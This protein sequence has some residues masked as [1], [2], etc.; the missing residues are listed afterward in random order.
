M[1]MK[2]RTICFILALLVIQNELFAQ[3]YLTEEYEKIYLQRQP[4]DKIIEL[5]GIKS[6]MTIGEVGA[7][8]GRM[9]V[10]LAREVGPSGKIYANDI[11]DL[12]LAYLKGR[13]RR[14]G[15]SNVDII[16]GMTDDPLL[17]EK[18]LDMA[19]MALVYHMLEK[20]DKLLENIKK[21]LKP[22]AVL[23]ILDPSDADID[24]EFGIDRSK[25]DVKTPTIR[26]RIANSASSAGYQV[27]KVDTTLPSDIIFTLRPYLEK[28]KIPAGEML[29]SIT[30]K[31]NIKAARKEFEKIKIDTLTYDL[32]EIE[33][34]KAGYEFI[35]SRSYP[36]AVA[37]LEMGIELYPGSAMLL[38]EMGEAYLMQGDKEKSLESWK[39]AAALDPENPNGKYLIENFD[40]VYEQIHP[41]K[42]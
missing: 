40:A 11:D 25:P 12:S 38:A 5:L 14:L 18:K 1:N 13:C 3:Y 29:T 21:S 31:N 10:Y 39:R 22:G 6:G 34:R 37:I 41:K 2:V 20:P 17:P 9:T 32:S 19:V 4:P 24:R 36:E 28:V 42:K 33:F 30:L 26:E 23:V 35:G 27:V 7:G 15:F 8:R 16:K